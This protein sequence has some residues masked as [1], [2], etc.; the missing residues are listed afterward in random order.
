MKKSKPKRK[1]DALQSKSPD[2]SLPEWVGWIVLGLAVIATLTISWRKWPDPLV[3]FGRELYLPW[4]IT[5]GAVLYR[6]IDANYGPLSHY[7]NAFVFLIFGPGFMHLVAVNL[8]IYVGILSLL[9][10]ILRI[11]WGRSAAFVGSL[12][13]VTVFSFNQFVGIGNYNYAAP[14][15][16]ETTHGFL[17]ILG[18]IATLAAWLQHPR[19][20]F[21]GLAGLL[22]GLCLL[23][24]IEVIFTATFVTLA[25]I[26]LAWR[27]LRKSF[28]LQKW[29]PQI[30]T[31]AILGMA[32]SAIATL[33][34]FQTGKFSIYEAFLWANVAWTGLFLYKDIAQDPLQATF[35]GLSDIPKNLYY[36][37]IAGVY[38]VLSV[39]ITA[40][41]LRLIGESR[42]TLL[43]LVAIAI[44]VTAIFVSTQLPWIEVARAFPAWL[45]LASLAPIFSWRSSLSL[46]VHQ[47]RFLLLVAAWAFLARM[48]IN[49]RVYHYGFFQAAIAGVLTVVVAWKLLPDL[50]CLQKTQRFVYL[51]LLALFLLCGVW[52][53]QKAS[54]NIYAKK[55]QSLGTGVDQ[56]FG[57]N[58]QVE[59]TTAILEDARKF[60]SQAPGVNSLL[61]L[62]EG[63]T[64]NYLLRKNTP[65]HVY[66]FNPYWLKWRESILKDINKNPPSY[67]LL[68][69]RDMREYGIQRFGET[70]EHGAQLVS[71]LDWNCGPVHHVGGDPLDVSERGAIIYRLK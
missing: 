69:S 15:A 40:A 4:Q 53:L 50:F 46:G 60:L 7:F 9:Y 3:D 8:V 63:I 65:S 5:Q 24:K 56:M 64:L 33:A 43:V 10:Y 30:M 57:F 38:S 14:Y 55:T 26:I 13:F 41:I 48:A 16:H 2:F 28:I 31:F 45:I 32:P 39:G 35:L 21:S 17:L 42:R 54:T 1:S 52:Q 47:M 70:D 11:G 22:C 51:T 19:I 37:T 68:I 49:P 71:W 18:L 25:G 36:L 62:P 34:L 59:P 44:A 12:F 23:L 58:A 61:V 27:S 20:F 67:V 29:M 6:D 66:T